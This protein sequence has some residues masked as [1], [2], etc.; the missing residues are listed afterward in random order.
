AHVS[1]SEGRSHTLEN[2]FSLYH[3][4]GLMRPRFQDVSFA[5]SILNAMTARRKLAIAGL[6][7]IAAAILTFA[8]VR[9]AAKPPQAVCLLPEGE[10]LIYVNL[11]P[12]HF[13]DSKTSNSV[14]PDPD[15]QAF[16]DQTN[17]RFERDLDQVAISMR[18]PGAEA[19]TSSIFKGRFDL[20][21]L[22]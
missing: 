5:Y 18:N 3:F 4:A 8:A 21:K 16:I 1:I 14:S 22:Q 12:L 13:F 6:C 2:R 9:W 19:E 11:K 15:Y 7:M 10:L 20:N 17:I